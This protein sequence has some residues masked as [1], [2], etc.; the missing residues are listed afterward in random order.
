MHKNHEK[1]RSFM[2]PAPVHPKAKEFEI[3]DQIL[4]GNPNIYNKAVQDLTKG[5]KKC[6]GAKGMSAEQ[7]VRAALIK[8]IDH[9][10]Y[11]ELSFH[12]AD[13]R[14]YSNFCKIG[15]GDKPFKKSALQKNIKSL[16][17]E[18]WEQINPNVAKVEDAS[19]LR[20]KG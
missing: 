14:T 1:Q 11:N 17:V 9:F 18:T 12:I 6:T 10:S 8:R 2:E 20:R 5:T 13:S 15:F 16:S 7:V 4:E 3:I 19:D